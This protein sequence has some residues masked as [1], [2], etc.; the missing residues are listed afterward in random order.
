MAMGASA[1]GYPTKPVRIVIPISA[2]S[3]LDI[4]G[5]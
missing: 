4:V 3:G 5:R 2:G 1:Q